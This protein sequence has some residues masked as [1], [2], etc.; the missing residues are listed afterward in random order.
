MLDQPSLDQLQ[1]KV[2]QFPLHDCE[3]CGRRVLVL[4][5]WNDR[6]VCL[7]CIEELLIDVDYPER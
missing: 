5:R 2:I 7:E 1:V 6:E 3:V 4:K